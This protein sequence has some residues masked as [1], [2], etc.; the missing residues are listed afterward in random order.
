MAWLG[1][2]KAYIHRQALASLGNIP[3]LNAPQMVLMGGA[4]SPA[5]G[6]VIAGVSFL[7]A[8]FSLVHLKYR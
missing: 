2:S 5:I 1:C 4:V 3:V 6:F 8:Y 7:M